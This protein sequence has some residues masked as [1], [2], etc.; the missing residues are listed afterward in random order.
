MSRPTPF[1]ALVTGA[2]GGIGH[3]ICRALI[4]QAGRDGRALTLT[5]T[6]SRAGE[7]LDA[8]AAGL[9]APGV[10]V[11]ALG[12]DVTDPARCR[13]LV[14]DVVAL[15]GDLSALVCVAGASAPGKLAEMSVEQ[16]DQCFHL[17][18]RS[19]WLMAQ[20]ARPSLLRT[21]GSITAIASMTG[22]QPIPGMGAYS[23]AKAALVM[24]CRQ[25]AQ[26]WGPDGI[27]TNTVCP[28]MIRTPLTEAVYQDDETRARRE[29]LVPVGRIGTPADIGHA[30]AY[31]VSEGASYVNG[32]DLLVDGG[33]SG[34]MMA[35]IPGRPGKAA[36][37]KS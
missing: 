26:E 8:L 35:M 31:L 20:A 3:G 24:L 9:R 10:T 1:H 5:V 17:N 2:T 30:V 4:D 23:P 6:G 14:E 25:L 16:W 22:L 29:A 15:G 18:T 7:K 13:S 11:H 21:R 33:I 32:V 37:P 36:A 34:H 28:G 12:G 19:V 27:R